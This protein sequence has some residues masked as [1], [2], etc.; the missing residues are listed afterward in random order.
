MK[1]FSSKNKSRQELNPFIM[2]GLFYCASQLKN[3]A[4]WLEKKTSGYTSR[5]L[6][7][8]LIGFCF[9]FISGSVLIIYDSLNTR[10][11]SFYFIVPIRPV[12]L[13]KDGSVRPFI[14]KKEYNRI[15]AFKKHIDS[16]ITTDAGQM[17][18]KKLLYNH[19]HLLD[20]I[21]HIENIYYEQQTNK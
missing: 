18:A 8:L 14:T 20:S 11:N 2:K 21:T 1:I 15:H 5:Q 10:R 6:K 17:K 4:A 16:L 9:M 7:I 19:P 13:L 12:P 3:F